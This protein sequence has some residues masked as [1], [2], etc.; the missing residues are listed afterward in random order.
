MA[1]QRASELARLGPGERKISVGRVVKM[2]LGTGIDIVEVARIEAAISR[3]G[4]RLL[5]RI[6]TP[7]ERRYC[8][9]R[10][11]PAEHY[12]ARFAAKEAGLKAIGTGWSQGVG[13]AELEVRR[14]P[15]GR[16]V[17]MFCGK[18]AKIA[19]ELGVTRVLL[20]LS[21]TGGHA[22]AQVILE[23]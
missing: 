20:S 3:F 6:F 22:I 21:H 4:D 7:E 18:A 23:G 9:S 11:N 14:E 16:P 5:A 19:A 2:I 10:A 12:A 17:L 1:W 8:A 15:S 13:W